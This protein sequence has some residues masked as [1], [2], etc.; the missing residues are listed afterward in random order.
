MG[1][2]DTESRPARVSER[3]AVRCWRRTQFLALGFTPREA[4]VLT[5]APVD[6]GLVRKLVA[7]DCPLETVRRI[8]L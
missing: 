7:A 5:K 8:V 4:E 1:N 6:V 2:Q 3:T